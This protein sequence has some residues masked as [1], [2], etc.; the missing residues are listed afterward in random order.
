[1]K[2]FISFC[3]ALIL[4]VAGSSELSAQPGSNDII[5][6][7]TS[8]AR[9]SKGIYVL[10]FDRKQGK[11]KELQ[12][13][14]EGSGP[15]FLALSPDRK[16][17]YSIYGKGTLGDGKSAV[18][19]FK[20][21]PASGFLTKL[22]EQSAEGKGSAHISID[23]KGRYAY[24]SN[25]GEGSITVLPINNDG[26][27]AK[28]S[29]HIRHTGKSIDPDRQTKP[30]PHSAIPSADGKFLYVS[31]LG[32]DK[33]M[34]YQVL[35]GAKLKPASVP[36]AD[37]VAGSGPRHFKIHPNGKLAYSVGEMSNTIV[38]FRVNKKTGAL[39]TIERLN[40]LPEGFKDVSYA[41]DVHFSPDGKFIYASNRGHESLVI[42]SVNAKSGKLTLVGHEPTG[43]KHP[44]NF[45]MDRKGEFVL[46]GNMNTDNV[47][48]FNR[49]KETGKLK[50]NGVQYT[51][52]GITCLIQL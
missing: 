28:A 51:I 27:L 42:Y 10:E 24:V 17:L 14:T 21:D 36:F 12:T 43:G 7:G 18:M 47:V 31:D 30:Y 2:K 33:I 34:I 9:G 41:S 29:E 52:P 44:R 37:V 1:M 6:A 16:F 20:I 39:S 26:T 23:P 4:F 15:G 35:E 19:S 38:G 40:M 48:V 32:T 50:P 49:D 5:Y 45:M 46:V 8:S 3:I 22:N 13:L 11:L 25:Y